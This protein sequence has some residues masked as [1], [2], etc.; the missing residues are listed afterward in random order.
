TI[1]F[2]N[3]KITRLS[4]N[5]SITINGSQVVTNVT[6]GLL[7][8]LSTIGTITH[9]ITSNSMSLTFDNGNQRTWQVARRRVFTYNNGIVITTTGMHTSGATTGITEWGLNRFGNP[10]TTAISQPL[11]IRQ[12]CN[13]RLVSGKATHA[14]QLFNATA[15]FGLDATGNPT[16]CPGTANYYLKIEWMGP[17][18]IVRTVILPY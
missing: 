6:G 12:D 3:L 1:S 8:N 14:T 10:F 17:S 15:T 16:T 9:T 18:G 13:F 11:V 5:K 4:D 2:Q 7:M